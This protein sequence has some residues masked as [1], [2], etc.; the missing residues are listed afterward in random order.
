MG[1]ALGSRGRSGPENNLI[2]GLEPEPEVEL[3][4]ASAHV[5]MMR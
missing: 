4:F 3:K 1:P 2:T 5:M